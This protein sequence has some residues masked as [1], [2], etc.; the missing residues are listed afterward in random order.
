MR[1][2]ISKKSISAA[3]AIMFLTVL[4]GVCFPVKGCDVITIFY[5]GELVN[6]VRDNYGVP[7]IFAQTKEG[8]AF[9]CGYAM[10]QDRLWQADVYRRSAFGSLAEL[11]LATV[12]QDYE[13]RKWGY[14]KA[15]L[16]EI[17]EKWTPKKPHLKSMMEAYVEGI[18]LYITQ[19]QTRA[20]LYGDYSMIPLEYIPQV[21]T[22]D[23]LLPIEPFTIEDCVAITV[24]MAW[25]FGGCGGSELQYAAALQDLIKKHGPETGWLIF[26]DLFPQNDPGAE[27]TIPSDDC[28]VQAATAK[29]NFQF[30]LPENIGQVYER[31]A[32]AKGMLDQLFDSLGLPTKFGS[33]AWMVSS[34]KSVSGNALQV[35]GPQMGHSIPQIVLEVGLHGAGIDAVGMIM[36]QGPFIL[37][38]V[39]EYGA[40]T[41]TT[42]VSDVMDTYIEVLNPSNLT[43]YL[44]NGQWVPMEVRFE[45][46]YGYKKNTYVDKPVYRTI[47]GP[48]FAID[49]TNNLAYT[50]KTPYYKNELAAEEG[51][52]HFQEARN[53]EEFQEAVKLIQP[54]HNFYWIDRQGNIGY[55]HAGTFPIKPTIGKNGRL[56]DDRLPLWGTGEEEWVG[57][58]G[59][60]EMPKCINP[61]QGWLANWNNKPIA[62]W[63]YAESDAQWGQGHRVKRL[64]DLL[65]AKD[66]FSFEDMNLIN[67][68]AGYNHIPG[69]NFLHY[70]VEAAENAAPS[71]PDVAAA[72]LYLKAWNH[73]YND[74]LDPR[75]P[76]KE[77]TYDDPGLTIFDDWYTRIRPAVFADDIP[78]S[79]MKVTEWQSSTLIHVFDGVQSKLPLNYDYLNGED[80]D[81][82]IVRVLK[83][84]IGNLTSMYG[85]S[86]M[87]KWLTPVRTIK[88]SRLG[89]LPAPTMHYMN[90]GTYNHIA[91]MPTDLL[92]PPKAVNVI[93]P[94]QSGFIC[95]KDSQIVISP[96]AYDQLILYETWTYKPARIRFLSATLDIQPETLNL[97]GTRSR[98]AGKWITA[99]IELPENYDVAEI[100]LA[101]IMLNNTIPVDLN[102]PVAIDDYDNDGILDL[103]V[104][105]DKQSVIDYI[106]SKIDSAKFSKKAHITVTLTICGLLNNGTPFHGSTTIKL[107]LPVTKKK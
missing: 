19:A 62:N 61:E 30:N 21:I 55:W 89:A 38:G 17:Y 42:G 82:V 36:P 87:S 102:A 59:F 60:D 93:P 98:R 28:N 78:S 76:A 69:M 40:W 44:Y 20:S 88:F 14:S 103:M 95:L 5:N 68:D 26:N 11:G 18:N 2:K 107:T 22:P 63:P 49:I 52:M 75:W 54:S 6:I 8:L 47:H 29:V 56:I 39:S 73:H 33:N 86:D 97:K 104:K 92:E 10:A 43:Q 105:F 48:V 24:M 96:H 81:E 31:Y 85:T 77:A 72:L 37:I 13:I 74:Y 79:I 35:G 91:E 90:R 41:S 53:I 34:S 106:L 27:V 7:H 80:R 58:T 46:I 66:K 45:R 12:E 70:L 57:L 99:Y 23:G 100:N 51:W 3:F 67:M 15:E 9:G 101:S 25:R 16:R 64:L 84:T 71:N 4:I 94:G 65:A 50:M 83:W 32:E 1:R